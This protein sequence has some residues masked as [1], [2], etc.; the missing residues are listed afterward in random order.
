[1]SSTG[2]FYKFYALIF[3]IFPALLV[4]IKDI[5]LSTKYH[6]ISPKHFIKSTVKIKTQQLPTFSYA[7]N[8]I[9]KSS[10]DTLVTRH[11]FF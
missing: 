9:F 10:S 4:T 3:Y 8:S 2:H 11:H 7:K 1:M 6:Y 5:F